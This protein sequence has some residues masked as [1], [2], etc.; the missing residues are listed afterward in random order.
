MN[1]LRLWALPL[2]FIIATSAHADTT[3]DPDVPVDY[4]KLNVTSLLVQ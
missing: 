2:I 4:L 3:T 1:C